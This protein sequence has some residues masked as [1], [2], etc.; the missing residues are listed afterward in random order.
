MT[1]QT[2]EEVGFVGVDAEMVEL[3]LRLGPREGDGALEGRRVVMFVGQVEHFAARARDQRP[4][5]DPR[6]GPWRKPD[7]AAKTEDRIEYG[8]GSVG[9][10]PAVNH[11]DRR[12]DPASPSQE[13]R[14]ISLEL[15]AAHDLAFD[16]RDMRRP[17]FVVGGRAPA[18]RSQQ[19][20]AVGDE[21]GLY[22]QIGEGRVGGV[23]RI[24]CQH[25]L[26][27]RGQLD[28]P[29]PG[30]EIRDRDS[31]HLSVVLRRHRDLHLGLDQSRRA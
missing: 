10:R 17:E 13:T 11:R 16:H 3:H 7:A 31:T 18:P 25:H 29:H 4:E 20:A 2:L 27:V 30:T 26:R 19:S 15:R 1:R 23:S 14:P 12:A 9:E 6:R 21:F 5:R 24:G 8:A 22:E 28:L